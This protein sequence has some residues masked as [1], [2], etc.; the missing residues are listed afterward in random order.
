M[1][2]C[3]NK[4]THLFLCGFVWNI[5]F[6]AKFTI[7]LDNDLNQFLLKSILVVVQPFFFNN[8]IPAWGLISARV[9]RTYGGLW[10]KE[11]TQ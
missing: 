6:A 11:E 5:K 8:G 4:F 7:N 10:V 9:L 1:I 3:Q 2:V